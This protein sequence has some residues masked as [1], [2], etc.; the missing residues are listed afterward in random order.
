MN[1][2]E[3]ILNI[4]R[5]ILQIECCFQG[6]G[7]GVTRSADHLSSESR[8]LVS[9]SFSPIKHCCLEYLFLVLNRMAPR[10]IGFEKSMTGLSIRKSVVKSR[11]IDKRVLKEK[12]VNFLVEN[13]VKVRNVQVSGRAVT[14][15]SDSQAVESMS[16]NST[17]QE[18]SLAAESV[19]QQILRILG[20]ISDDE[21]DSSWTLVQTRRFAADPRLNRSSGLYGGEKDKK[22]EWHSANFQFN[23]AEIDATKKSGF[24][25]EWRLIRMPSGE[26]PSGQLFKNIFTVHPFQLADFETVWKSFS[27]SDVSSGITGYRPNDRQNRLPAGQLFKN[28]FTVHPFQLADFETVWKSFSSS[29][30]SSGITGYRPNHRQNR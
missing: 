19:E 7:S 11:E 20:E 23:G 1:V 17:R 24:P 5:W 26:L 29:E 15:K 16:V 10:K 12:A 4:F 6:V 9:F 3:C 21:E 28:I 18:E 30:V 27:S 13:S 14:S 2:F 22:V 8:L 25:R